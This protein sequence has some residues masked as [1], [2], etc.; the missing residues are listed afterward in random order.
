[1]PSVEQFNRKKVKLKG[2]LTQIK[3]KVRYKEI[4]LSIVID[5]M[6][7]TELFLTG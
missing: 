5:Q 2:F 7:Y 4:K 1:M 3:L 6:A